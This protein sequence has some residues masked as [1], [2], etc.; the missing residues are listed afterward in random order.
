[1]VAHN[2]ETDMTTQDVRSS[3]PRISPELVVDFNAYAA[4]PADTDQFKTLLDRRKYAVDVGADLLWTNQ[5]GGHWIATRG[6]TIKSIFADYDRFSTASVFIGA[7]NPEPLVP[8][9]YDEPEH[10]CF[11]K[12]LE[13]TFR[14]ASVAFWASEA[15]AL[16]I[17]LIENIQPS[18]R[19][20]FISD[21]AENLPII[22]FLKIVDLPLS[23]RE[24]LLKLVNGALRPK[25][26]HARKA[27]N[28]SVLV[29]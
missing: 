19:C 9:E 15:R 11:R 2:S 22:I 17:E 10:G 21:F 16:A 4:V 13:P 1:M 18:G 26:E 23:D 3:E 14:P 29:N 24:H 8:A 12:L 7:P 20:E 6:E 27:P 25:S 28:V 5:N